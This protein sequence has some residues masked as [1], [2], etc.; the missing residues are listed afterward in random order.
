MKTVGRE[1][2]AVKYF[3]FKPDQLKKQNCKLKQKLKKQIKANLK[4]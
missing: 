2:A 3:D 4:K 1:A